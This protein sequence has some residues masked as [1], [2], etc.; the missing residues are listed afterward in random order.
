M[1]QSRPGDQRDWR[2]ERQPTRDDRNLAELLQEGST[3]RDLYV[4]TVALAAVAVAL[5]AVI[6]AGLWL[7]LPLARRGYPEDGDDIAGTSICAWT[8]RRPR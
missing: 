7:A 6:F 1:T 8:P 4:V 2:G 5:A 3:Q